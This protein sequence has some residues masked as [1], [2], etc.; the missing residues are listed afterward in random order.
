MPAVLFGKVVEFK[1]LFVGQSQAIVLRELVERWV[2][3]VP[4]RVLDLVGQLPCEIPVPVSQLLLRVHDA[5]PPQSRDSGQLTIQL[6]PKRSV[7]MPK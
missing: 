4:D 3:H 1:L 6:M 5:T 2:A 7:H